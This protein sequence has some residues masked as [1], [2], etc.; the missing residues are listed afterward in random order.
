MFYC[1]SISFDLRNLTKIGLGL[2]LPDFQDEKVFNSSVI[3]VWSNWAGLHCVDWDS[4]K[5]FVAWL[6][7]VLSGE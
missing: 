5:D 2:V 3:G 1:F 4:C 7:L 6:I